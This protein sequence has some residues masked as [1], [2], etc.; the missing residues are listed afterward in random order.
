M[1]Y[2]IGT[3]ELNEPIKPKYLTFIELVILNN[4]AILE[5]ELGHSKA[6]MEYLEY[7]IAYFSKENSV[8][9]FR[10]KTLIVILYNLST[11]KGQ[12][13]DFQASLALAERGIELCK[14]YTVMTALPYLIFNKGY[15]LASLKDTKN[16]KQ[17]IT[18]ALMLM[19]ELGIHNEVVFGIKQLE[20]E[21]GFIINLN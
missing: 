16:G 11:W 6:A 20:K 3:F 7:I 15:A 2:T 5:Y 10:A 17:S 12:S 18:A 8:D 1:R 19:E 14:T 21:F 9:N 13:H 4:I